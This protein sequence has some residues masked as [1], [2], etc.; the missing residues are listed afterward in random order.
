MQKRLAMTCIAQQ[1]NFILTDKFHAEH[2]EV[3]QMLTL[4]NS[5]AWPLCRLAFGWH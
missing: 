1:F 2:G 3:V 4:V 5:V